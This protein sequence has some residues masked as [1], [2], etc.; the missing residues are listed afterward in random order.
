[1][2]N[3]IVAFILATFSPY[4]GAEV[5][6]SGIA[7]DLKPATESQRVACLESDG[8]GG[9]RLKV[10]SMSLNGVDVNFPTAVCGN[11]EVWK[12]DGANG[13]TCAVVSGGAGG[14]TINTSTGTAGAPLTSSPQRTNLT[15][16]PGFTATDDISLDSTLINIGVGGNVIK[17]TMVVTC[18]EDSTGN[19]FPQDATPP[20]IGEVLE[21]LSVNFTPT[22]SNNKIRVTVSAQVGASAAGPQCIAAVFDDSDTSSWVLPHTCDS[23]AQMITI[24]GE[25]EFPGYSGQHT[26]RLGIGT[27]TT[28]TTTFLNRTFGTANYLGAGNIC[29]SLKIEEVVE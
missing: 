3:F 4:A 23:S 7:W 17:S 25:R 10:S 15:F 24:A 19:D 9:G 13:I 22:N 27:P 16:G 11:G 26:W 5:S 21:V 12:H 18:E 28:A 14:H 29:T 8:A 2:R 1:M 20:L 6:C